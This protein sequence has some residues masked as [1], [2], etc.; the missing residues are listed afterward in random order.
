MTGSL[1]K[2]NNGDEEEGA[3]QSSPGS[4][5]GASGGSNRSGRGGDK[6]R[7]LPDLISLKELVLQIYE[8]YKHLWTEDRCEQILAFGQK[9]SAAAGKRA[10]GT[11]GG[12]IG[13]VVGKEIEMLLQQS[14]RFTNIMTLI[15]IRTTGPVQIPEKLLKEVVSK[16][17]KEERVKTT[18]TLVDK[19]ES[20]ITKSRDYA[21]S[22]RKLLK[23]TAETISGG[24]KDIVAALEKASDNAQEWAANIDILVK[25]DFKDFLASIPKGTTSISKAIETAQDYANNIQTYSNLFAANYNKITIM[26]QHPDKAE[27]LG[28]KV[29]E[30]PQRTTPL[31]RK[32]GVKGRL[33]SASR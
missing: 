24:A 8:K 28:Q 29:E 19:L 10:S 7:Q 26:I 25:T 27:E 3:A 4:D 11:V 14:L 20:I 33:T 13:N 16:A 1:W 6:S 23:E 31:K 12:K 2:R 9:L 30:V 5:A 15:N 21:K 18:Y 32:G 17:P 22:H